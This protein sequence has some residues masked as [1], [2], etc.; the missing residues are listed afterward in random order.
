MRISGGERLIEANG[1]PDH[2]PGQFPRRGNPNRIS[3]QEYNFQVPSHPQTNERPTPVNH[4]LFGVALNGVPF[5]PGTAEFWNRDR[6]SG[7]NYEAKGSSIDL[8]LDEHNAHVQPTGAYHYHGVPIG[9]AQKTGEN[10]MQLVGYAADGFPMY[11]SKVYANH[12]D[13]SA[14]FKSLRSS[15]RLKQ[16]SRNG[17]PGGNYDGSFTADWEYVKGAGD[18]D[19]CNGGFGVTPQY[20]AG[21]YFYCVTEEF[22]FIPR[23]WR[24]TPD[25]SFFKKPPMGTPGGSRERPGRP[26]FGEV[27]QEEMNLVAE[28]SVRHVKN[29][30]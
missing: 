22:P 11:T 19:E 6:L 26:R 28:V 1:I 16:G 9:L 10:Q 25:R 21:T 4:A 2:A 29:G 17:G 20:P 14:G 24:G 3:E 5:D 18:L 12:K 27:K 30:K 7:W 13:S 23:F 8:G 15:Y